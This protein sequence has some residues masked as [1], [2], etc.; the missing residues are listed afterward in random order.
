MALS[1]KEELELLQLEEEEYQH[2]LK[3]GSP[4]AP[5]EAKQEGFQF[6]GVFQGAGEALQGGAQEFVASAPA[7]GTGAAQG[8]TFGFS[9][10][11][12]ATADVAGDVLSGKGVPL[13]NPEGD[14]L[15]GKW[16]EY[17]KARE[18]ANKQ[19]QAES[20]NAYLAGEFG[21]AIASA[22]LAPSVGAVKGA[23]WIGKGIQAPFNAGTKLAESVGSLSPEVA[24]FLAGKAPSAMGKIAGAGTKMAIEGLPAGALYGAGASEHDLSSSPSELAMDTVNSGL[25]GSAT[26]LAIGAGAK[27]APMLVDAGKRGLNSVDFFRKLG[28]ASDFADEGVEFSTSAGKDKIQKLLQQYPDEMQEQMLGARTQLGE[29]VRGT[30]DAAEK[31]GVRINVNPTL[32][33]NFID[34]MNTF[35]NNQVLGSVMDPKSKA[36]LLR[37]A[38]GGVGDISPIEAKALRESVKDA[39]KK[40]QGMPSE[41]AYIGRSKLIELDNA[42]T[43]QMKKQ[44]PGYADEAKKFFEYNKGV[45]EA[46]LEP[47]IPEHLRS[48]TLS[49]VK[50]KGKTLFKAADDVL[51]SA[52]RP[53]DAALPARGTLNEMIVNLGE[54]EK[55]APEVMKNFGMKGPSAPLSAEEIGAKW[56]N[57]ADRMAVLRQ[58]QGTSPHEGAVKIAKGSV[59]GSGEGMAYGITNRG[60]TLYNATSQSWPVQAAKKAFAYTDD[61]LMGLANHLKSLEASKP[62]GE[63]LEKALQNK[64]VAA[65]NAALFKLL[66]IPEYRQLLQN[67]DK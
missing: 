62:L 46:M 61:S 19:I 36:A 52:Y 30:L 18:L 3:G 34:V 49:G 35:G 44:I 17:Q 22:G 41:I 59:L 54:T 42:L 43:E 57:Q 5:K 33:Q 58:S 13:F 15:G 27:A 37:V 8:S 56:K 64:D 67:G 32:N 16:R 6:P 38:Q 66:Q 9:D 1:E 28:V 26:G 12:G 24:T 47:G 31:A 63:A 11:L 2:S 21:G 23:G 29:Q 51:G 53:G 65:K 60:K 40:L 7:L 50:E 45:P 20:P 10:E 4:A 48:K 14:S 25:M 39:I 55:A